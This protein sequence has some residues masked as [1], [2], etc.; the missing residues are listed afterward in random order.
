MATGII[1]T[2]Q[3]ALTLSNLSITYSIKWKRRVVIGFQK[4]KRMNWCFLLD[5]CVCIKLLRFC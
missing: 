5:M 3:D 2:L 1:D 4:R